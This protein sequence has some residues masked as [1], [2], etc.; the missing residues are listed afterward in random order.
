MTQD[1]SWTDIRGVPEYPD[2]WRRSSS[3]PI[4]ARWTRRTPPCS[5]G[6]PRGPRIPLLGHR[7]E[8]TCVGNADWR[9]G[10]GYNLALAQRRAETVQRFMLERLGEF[11]PVLVP[12]GAQPRRAE[13]GPGQSLR[14]AHGRGPA[15]G[16]LL[17]LH[18]GTARRAAAPAGHGCPS[19]AAVRLP[20][21]SSTT[22]I[23][24]SAQEVMS[25]RAGNV[26]FD[27]LLR[28]LVTWVS[29]LGA[30]PPLGN[31]VATDPSLRRT[32]RDLP[33]QQHPHRT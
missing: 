11:R 4:P 20:T 18:P 29:R 10:T 28:S 3:P 30:A 15:G 16:R 24:G 17:Q 21:I 27:N 23:S 19:G 6:W 26:G 13:R 2:S 12:E 5:G 25:G 22:M 8:L 9:G 33:G 32:R 7:I 31:E 1:T 14:G